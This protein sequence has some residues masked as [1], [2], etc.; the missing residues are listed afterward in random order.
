MISRIRVLFPPSHETLHSDQSDHFMTQ[1]VA[2]GPKHSFLC[3][4]LLHSST[5]FMAPL[6]HLPLFFPNALMERYRCL[7]PSQVQ[8]QEDQSDHWSNSQSITLHGSVLQSLTSRLVPLNDPHS[9]A[10][11]AR[12]RFRKVL[13][14]SQV[15]EHWDHSVQSSQVPS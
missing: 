12:A 14:P 8:E 10:S 4:Y 11:V 2:G 6:H 9:F 5:S 13:P 15:L 1:S 3:V 7:M